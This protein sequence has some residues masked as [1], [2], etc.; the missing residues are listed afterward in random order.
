MP[1]TGAAFA[2]MD[3][4][5]R[6]QGGVLA[7][8][9]FGPEESR[10]ECLVSLPGL[11]LR[12]Y[13]GAGR[14]VLLVPAPIKRHYI[15]DL[16]PKVSVVRRCLGHGLAVYLCEWRD[17]A[18]AGYGLYDN[19]R[20]LVATLGIVARRHR[21]PPM[22][23]GHSLGGTLAAI[24]AAQRPAAVAALAVV[25]APLCFG[26]GGGSFSRLVAAHAAVEPLLPFHASVPGA[27]LSAFAA[28]AAPEVFQYGRW[29]DLMATAADWDGLRRHLRVERWV[30]DELPMPRRLFAD[31]TELLYRCNAFHRGRLDLGEGTL[32]PGGIHAPLL[33]IVDP[34]SAIVPPQ[35]VQPFL[36]AAAA[37]E[38]LVIEVRPE[39]GTGFPHLTALVGLRCHRAMWSRA[40]TWLSAAAW[41]QG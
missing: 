8:C 23:I 36:G 37:R 20:D 11:R 17:D 39:P 10:A 16:E 7:A 2:M 14:P 27:F 19:A 38:K 18:A 41:P 26:S 15:W 9:G 35:A 22:V 32:G 30:L 5:R 25:E 33:A 6:A 28:A 34:D 4:V 13:G 12:A 31:V 1:W 29:A 40:L 24:A 3:V 21:S